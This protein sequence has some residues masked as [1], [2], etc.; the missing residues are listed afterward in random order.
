MK[1]YIA[2]LS[3]LSMFSIATQAQQQEKNL[4]TARKDIVVAQADLKQAQKDSIAEYHQF[5]KESFAK[6]DENNK[7]IESLRVKKANE[8]KASSAVYDLK[9]NKLKSKNNALKESVVNYKADGNTNW[10]VFKR[11]FNSEMDS[12]RQSFIESRD[13]ESIH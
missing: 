13:A 8:E 5:R 4:K 3:T 6:I 11:Q 12:L 9:V 7:T 2:M 10:V 1:K